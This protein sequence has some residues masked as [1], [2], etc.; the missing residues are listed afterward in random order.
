MSSKFEDATARHQKLIQAARVPI[1]KEFG[2]VVEAASIFDL[3]WFLG[4]IDEQL[5]ET[6]HHVTDPEQLQSTM[7]NTRRQR[8]IVESV[9]GKKMAIQSSNEKFEAGLRWILAFFLTVLGMIVGAL[10]AIYF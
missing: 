5:E 3:H 1:G 8:M 6:R 4:R 2:A 9:L 10:V 7:E